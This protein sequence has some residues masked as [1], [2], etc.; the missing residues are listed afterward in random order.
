MSSTRQASFKTTFVIIGGGL[1]GLACGYALGKA[2]H[3]VVI[4]ERNDGNTKAS[5]HRDKH[6]K[7]LTLTH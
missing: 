2:G 1:S 5:V 6:W 7:L 4:I 3:D